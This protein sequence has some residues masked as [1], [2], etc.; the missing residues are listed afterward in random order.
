VVRQLVS[1][2]AHAADYLA[3]DGWV[4]DDELF[5][6][7]QNAV[8]VRGAV[9]STSASSSVNAMAT[10]RSWLERAI[11]V[12]YRPET[13]RQSHY[14]GASLADQFDAVVHIDHTTALQPLERSVLWTRGDPPETFP[15]GIRL[16]TLSG[17]RAGHVDDQ[18]GCR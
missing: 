8:V 17:E 3:G 7:E 10:I 18:V 2:R 16:V 6:A 5:Q 4:A 1:L 15:T 11:G 13:E 12:I 9:S 14:F